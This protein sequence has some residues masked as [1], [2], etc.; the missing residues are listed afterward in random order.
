MTTPFTRQ[1]RGL[2]PNAQI[3]FWGTESV[4]LV[5]RQNPYISNFV[6]I[7][8]RTLSWRKPQQV[9]KLISDIRS[10]RYDIGFALGR[11][12]VFALILALA[13]VSSR[14]GFG[15]DAIA[16]L[17]LQRSYPTTTLKHEVHL[18]LDLLQSFGA[19]SYEDNDFNFT[20]LPGD[21]QASKTLIQENHL[22]NFIAVV[23]SGGNNFNE[24]SQVR[25]LPMDKF[26]QLINCLGNS[27]PQVVLIGD[28]H[29]RDRYQQLNLPANV[30]NFAGKMTL[31]QTVALLKHAKLVITTDCGPMHFAAITKVPMIAIFGP[32]D[33]KR[34]APF[35]AH[36]VWTDEDIYQTSYD[37]YGI[38]PDRKFFERIDP[39]QLCELSRSMSDH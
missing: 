30:I 8:Q 3:D 9:L 12:W 22:T 39:R 24:S 7:P 17:L 6:S 33:P 2:F 16:R 13:Q 1:L 26:Q 27:H 28:K 25:M 5:Y 37:L 11:S 29:D 31:P 18:Y 38:I 10:H 35:K 20:L 36:V 14:I 4:A 15:R 21:E 23:N 34:K 32:T 19:V